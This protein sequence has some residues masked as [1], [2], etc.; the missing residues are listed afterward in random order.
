LTAK[1]PV[2]I[3][4]VSNVCTLLTHHFKRTEQNELT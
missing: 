1:S 4:V 3:K 2:K